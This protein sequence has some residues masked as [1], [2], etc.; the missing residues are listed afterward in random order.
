MMLNILG[1]RM[2][3]QISLRKTKPLQE[4]TNKQKKKRKAQFSFK[5]PSLDLQYIFSYLTT[6]VRMVVLFGHFC[7]TDFCRQP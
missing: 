5:S 2:A 4:E 7:F 6:L 1:L 3:G